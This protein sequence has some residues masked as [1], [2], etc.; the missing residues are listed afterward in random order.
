M[1]QNY[2]FSIT[3]IT[4]C[5]FA[6][7]LWRWPAKDVTFF[8]IFLR[9]LHLQFLK[10]DRVFPLKSVLIGAKGNEPGKWGNFV[11]PFLIKKDTWQVRKYVCTVF[12]FQR[13]NATHMHEYQSPFKYKFKSGV[14]EQMISKSRTKERRSRKER[15]GEKSRKEW[16]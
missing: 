12:K 10:I 11:M 4:Q 9:M 14:R 7:F 15:K 1:T 6:T 8:T 13:K 2:F 16:T 3:V 5:M